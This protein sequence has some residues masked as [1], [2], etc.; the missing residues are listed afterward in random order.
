MESICMVCFNVLIYLT[1]IFGAYVFV[2]KH[3]LNKHRPRIWPWNLIVLVRYLSNLKEIYTCKSS[4]IQTSPRIT[5]TYQIGIKDGIGTSRGRMACWSNFIS[6]LVWV[7]GWSSIFLLSLAS[8]LDLVDF[9]KGPC[10]IFTIDILWHPC[11]VMGSYSREK[12]N[13]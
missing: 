3:I 5:Q 11:A 2:Y 9:L 1:T 7:E 4:S 8:F 13:R 12:M 6:W 10:F